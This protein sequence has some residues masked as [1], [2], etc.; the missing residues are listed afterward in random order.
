MAIDEETTEYNLRLNAAQ[1]LQAIAEVNT[2]ASSIPEAL[3]NINTAL[4]QFAT[5]YGISLGAAQKEMTNTINDAKELRRILENPIA[6]P[7]VLLNPNSRNL[8]AT[9][10]P[11][12]SMGMSSSAG[13]K[14]LSD[15]RKQDALLTQ[16]EVR[17][18]ADVAKE[19]NKSAAEEDRKA[20]ALRNVLELEREEKRLLEESAAIRASD[21]AKRD[22]QILAARQA[23]P[24][25]ESKSMNVDREAEAAQMELN[26]AVQKATKAKAIPTQEEYNKAVDDGAEAQKKLADK[27]TQAGDAGEKGAN[28]A[29]FATRVWSVA[30][31]MLIHQGINL[32]ITSLQAMF[33]MAITGLR[34]LE[35]AT[36]N[37]VNAERTLSQQGVDITPKGMEESIKN[38][39][40]LDP[41]LSKIQA[42]EAVS[43]VS[44]LVA[45][46]VGFNAKE[47]DQLTQSIAVLAVKNK[48][49]GKSFEEVESQVSNAFLSGKVSVGI[50][51][52][53]VKI[54]DQIVKDEAL[55]MGLVKTAEEYD[56]L[57]GKMQANVKA[58]A[59][60]S[61]LSQ[62]TSKDVIHLPEFMKTA[63]AQ[64]TIFQARLQD[65]FTQI[66]TLAAP[67]LIKVLGLLIDGLEKTSA[68]ID[69]NKDALTLFADVAGNVV[70]IVLK[71]AAAFIK[72]MSAGALA[73]QGAVEWI[74]KLIDKVSWLK[75][76]AESLGF[77]GIGDAADTPTGTADPF[78]AEKVSVY[79]ARYEEAVADTEKKVTEIMKDA[80]E[81]RED[82]ER[83]YQNKLADLARDAARKLADIARSTGDKITDANKD[84][85]NKTADINSD[86]DKKI[87]DAKQESYKKSIDAEKKYQDELKNLRDKYLMDLEEALHARDARAILKLMQQ[88][89]LDKE[90]AL[91]NRNSEAK[92]AKVEAAQKVK[93]LEK[94]RKDKLQAA[95]KDLADKL[96]QIQI[97][98]ARERRDAQIAASRAL[99]DARQAYQRQLAEQRI[100]LQRKLADLAASIASEYNLTA[101]GA[102]AIRNLINA[103]ASGGSA[104]STSAQYTS[105]T[106]VVSST[107]GAAGLYGTGGMA[108]G[109]TFLA[110]RPG[111][112]NVAENR[113]EV[114]TATP[115]GKP[116]KDISKVFTNGSGMGGGMDGKIELG[117]TLSPDLEAR[118]I[119]Q[120][121]SETANVVLKIN[122]SK[123]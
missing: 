57:T 12:E 43:R 87:A 111:T 28:K 61:V 80:R 41:M 116:G 58:R 6:A 84:Y 49:L 113:P 76:L 9:P 53:G 1:M 51:Q 105:A 11:F 14:A 48:G 114:I 39:Q 8:A 97:A 18:Q 67:I 36:Y 52:L 50:N 2:K 115:L 3:G 118:I 47:I 112:I 101:A 99:A 19:L 103:T 85:R 96:K 26:Q 42:T 95:Q 108:E 69:K 10:D 15:Q 86:Y 54:T 74:Q 70:V 122:R 30:V 75:K 63:D 32:L 104:A 68:W 23:P 119:S 29:S 5:K 25:P 22:A 78:G 98:A 44:S 55:R 94:E 82:M 4:D 72:F 46:A 66:G 89:K 59:M 62:A 56:K 107:W 20:A 92:S 77:K 120:T 45:P 71:I 81:K 121:L 100:F 24:P 88:Y 65:F 79:G 117:L 102:A 34:E 7:S 73:F 40:K 38:L 109:G 21:K 37:L 16:Q 17:S 93:D 110:T 13:M 123:Q 91:E 106:P 35:T 90:K 31:G 60:L 64:F 83:D 33:T 27:V